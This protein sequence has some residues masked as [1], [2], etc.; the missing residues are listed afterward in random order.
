LGGAKQTGLGAFYVSNLGFILGNEVKKK[1]ILGRLYG[2]GSL[3]LLAERVSGILHWH[4]SCFTFKIQN[5]NLRNASAHE[6]ATLI[7]GP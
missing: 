2:K 6:Q 4:S 3:S 7:V 1:K 5:N